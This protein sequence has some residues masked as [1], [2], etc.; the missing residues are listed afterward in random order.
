M[1]SVYIRN[2]M[3]EKCACKIYL[4][5]LIYNIILKLLYYIIKYLKLL[6]YI[7]FKLSKY[8]II[9]LILLKNWDQVN[10]Y[11]LCIKYCQK[12]CWPQIAMTIIVQYE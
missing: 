2:L 1:L 5:K 6:Y 7:I 4:Y 10:I 9:K 3:L 11:I 12:E 8:L